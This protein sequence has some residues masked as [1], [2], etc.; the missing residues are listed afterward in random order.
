MNLQA[1]DTPIEYL[2]G[3]GAA[4]AD[5]LRKEAQIFNFGDLL[6]YLPYKYIDRTKFYKIANINP[7]LPYVQVLARVIS[8]EVIGEKHTKRLVVLAKD[9]TGVIELVWFQGIKWMEKNIFPGKVYVLFGKPG[10]F[11]GEPQMAH[12]EM[13]PYSSE[14]KER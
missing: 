11:N 14:E 3:V 7:E 12:P 5:I 6:R 9:D 13:E 2:R 1:F 10:S 4:R 8:K